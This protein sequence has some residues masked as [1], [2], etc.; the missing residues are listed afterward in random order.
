M[1]VE[2]FTNGLLLN[3]D[4]AT[5]LAALWPC[6]VGISLYSANPI[7]H[8]QIT[9]VPGSWEQTI[10]AIK[11]LVEKGITVKIFPFRSVICF[12]VRFLTET[13]R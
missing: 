13:L 2:L 11:R 5:K 7:I 10:G 1:D 4:K 12:R 9:R 6:E 3:E 8:D